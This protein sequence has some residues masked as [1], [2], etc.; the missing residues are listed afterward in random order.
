MQE[1]IIVLDQGMDVV[2]VADSAG[3]QQLLKL[4]RA[5]RNPTSLRRQTDAVAVYPRS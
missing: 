4:G 1:Q 2:K 5:L 3:E